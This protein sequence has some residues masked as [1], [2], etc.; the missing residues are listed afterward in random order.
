MGG[1]LITQREMETMTGMYAAEISK[2]LRGVRY[3]TRGDGRKY[4]ERRDAAQALQ[5]YCRAHYEAARK[6]FDV[7]GDRLSAVIDMEHDE[8][9][10]G[11]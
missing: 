4:Y 5:R 11:M 3:D 8:D 1:K 10:G 9:T 6:R 7:W 2:A